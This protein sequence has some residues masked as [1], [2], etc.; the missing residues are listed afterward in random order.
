MLEAFIVDQLKK[1]EE[2]RWIEDHSLVL[3]IPCELEEPPEK[4]E[5][6]RSIWKIQL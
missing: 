5:E 2:E 4:R 3:E 6:E 1:A